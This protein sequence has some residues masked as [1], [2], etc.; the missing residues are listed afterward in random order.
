MPALEERPPIVVSEPLE[1][2][3][4]IEEA[5]RRQRRRRLATSWLVVL[6]G[7]AAIIFGIASGGGPPAKTRPTSGAGTPASAS[8][9]SWHDITAP[10]GYIQAG[11]DITSVIRWRGRLYA[12]GNLFDPGHLT[13]FTCR[14]GCDPVVWTLARNGRWH[15]IF[16]VGADGGLASDQLVGTSHYLLLFS[17]AMSTE[18]WRSTDGRSWKPVK[19]PEG[20]SWLWRGSIASNGTNVLATFGNRYAGGPRGPQMRFPG[21]DPLFSSTDGVHWQQATPADGLG[22]EYVAVVPGGFVAVGASQVG[23]RQALVRS[24]SGRDWSV[25]S[26][27]SAPDGGYDLLAS[28]RNGIVLERIPASTRLNAPVQFLRS[29]NGREWTAGKVVGGGLT[30]RQ[31][32]G[33]MSQT[34]LAAPGG[35]VA[36]DETNHYI[37][38]ST[39]GHVWRRIAVPG[40]PPASFQ[41]SAASMDGDSLLVVEVPRHAADGVPSGASTIWQLKLR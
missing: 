12:T 6:L 20:M 37:W 33:P 11:A 7:V 22:F 17:G 31:L 36:L 2:E 25:L 16:A 4:L 39:N 15:P 23:R 29:T 26:P 27:L 40:G 9:L 18:L 19:I 10:G 21:I 8:G 30:N 32:K 35:F 1:P 3:V 34:L 14:V 13:G 41:P 28:S 38:W 24:K 5:R